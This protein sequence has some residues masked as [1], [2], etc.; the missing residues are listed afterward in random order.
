M[1]TRYFPPDLVTAN[2]VDLRGRFLF[3]GVFYLALLPAVFKASLG[4]GSLT[5]KLAGFPADLQNI[6]PARPFV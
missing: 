5:S 6:A 4:A 2:A 3:S 1:V